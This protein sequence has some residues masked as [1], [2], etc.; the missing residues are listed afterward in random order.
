VSNF[1]VIIL[2]LIQGFTE[3]L[4]ISSSAH[5]ILPSQLL[6]WADQGIAFD[7]AVHLGSLFAVLV[8]FRQE[9]WT[10]AVAWT[11]SLVG[12]GQTRDSHLAW[13]IILATIPAV[14]LGVVFK[15]FIEVYLRSAWV[16]AISTIVFGLLLWWVDRR[17]RLVSD[18]Y[19]V[20][21]RKALYIGFAQALAMVPGTSRSGITMTAGLHLGM[22]RQG[23]ARFSFLM[24]IPVIVGAALLMGKDLLE[25][26]VEVNWVQ[27]GLGVFISFLA[28][29]ACIHLFLR[30]VSRVGMM[31]FVV[32]RLVLGVTLL[33]FLLLS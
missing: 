17:A 27:I 5:L 23:A 25:V 1:E 2:A 18:E 6:G 19:Q 21:W 11:G 33:G 22:T 10:M 9:V 31:P 3:F 12:K 14:V 7:V 28:A 8:Y 26:P 32:Y 24:S 29:I 30:W 16:I 13:M 4:P 20:G 15:D